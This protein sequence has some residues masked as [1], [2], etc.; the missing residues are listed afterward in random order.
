MKATARKAYK[1]VAKYL[2]PYGQG[3]TLATQIATA[4][5]RLV[6]KR[7]VMSITNRVRI[8]SRPFAT[9]MTRRP[10]D[11]RGPDQNKNSNEGSN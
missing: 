6:Y 10:D 1:L 2:T 8:S 5:N 7:S 3:D 11:E 4:V 9:K